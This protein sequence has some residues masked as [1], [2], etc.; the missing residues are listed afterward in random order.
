MKDLQYRVLK[1]VRK[2]LAGAPRAASFIVTS[3]DPN[4][5]DGLGTLAGDEIK[6]GKPQGS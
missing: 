2:R 5:S 6:D 1:F 4:A 3:Y